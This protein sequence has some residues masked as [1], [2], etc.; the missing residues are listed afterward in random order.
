MTNL[1]TSPEH[2]LAYLAKADDIPH[3]AE[4]ES[5]LLEQLP[6][7]VHRILDLGTGD[8]RLLAL[9][10][11]ARPDIDTA[12]GIDFSATM[13]DRAAERFADDPRVTLHQRDL[14]DSV[15]D[16]GSYDVVVSS[17][18]IHHVNDARKRALYAEVFGLLRAG[19]L[20]L[21]LEHVSSSTEALHEAFLA[22]IGVD[23]ADDDPSNQLADTWAQLEWLRAVGFTDV[24]CHWK[25]R[26]LA[27]L[28]GVKP[29]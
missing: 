1:W 19:A 20:F 8:G 29:A 14:D 13:L 17:F 2:A 6:S 15:S 24:D 21:N 9:V 18:A 3:R 26:E 27:L 10:L 22:A 4:G 23:P 16:L 28:G 7:V 11:L 25:W 5:A 12:V